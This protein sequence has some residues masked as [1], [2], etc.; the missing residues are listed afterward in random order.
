LIYV[1]SFRARCTGSIAPFVLRTDNGR[2]VCAAFCDK[3][4]S[5]SGSTERRV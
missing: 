5:H 1:L 3:M 4:S 2:Y